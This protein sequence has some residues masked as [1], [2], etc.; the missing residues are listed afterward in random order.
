MADLSHWDIASSFT[1]R[2]AAYLM[3]GVDPSGPEADKYSARHISER[4]EAAY[5]GAIKRAEFEGYVEPCF[6]FDAPEPENHMP[7]GAILRSEELWQRLE[8]F[9]EHGDD[10]TFTGWLEFGN[11]S[12][13]GRRFSRHELA[14]WLKENNMKSIYRFDL[15]S[16]GTTTE[17]GNTHGLHRGEKPL[18]TRERDTL[19][20]IIAALCKDVGYDYTKAAKA[21]A[22]IQRTSAGMGVSIGET[23]IEGHLKK[24]PD[25]LA[26]RMK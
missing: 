1:L 2:E 24:I 11:H 9:R 8:S 22:M 18:G 13:G 20:T 14:R 7:E 12:H 15:Q 16:T 17:S 3:M 26:T 23:T 4:L 25:A 6:P 10:V 19:L 21:A 5:A